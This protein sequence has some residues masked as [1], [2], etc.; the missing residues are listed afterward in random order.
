MPDRTRYTCTIPEPTPEQRTRRELGPVTVTVTQP[1]MT[2][3]EALQ[4]DLQAELL[5]AMLTEDRP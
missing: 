1:V 3:L 2:A 5:R 4:R